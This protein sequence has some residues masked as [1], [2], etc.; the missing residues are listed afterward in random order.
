MVHPEAETRGLAIAGRTI[1][2]LASH[3]LTATGS[4]S[5]EGRG[6]RR[7]DDAATKRPR[8]FL[9]SMTDMWA[10]TMVL[11]DDCSVVPKTDVEANADENGTVRAGW[12]SQDETSQ[13]MSVRT[14]AK[15]LTPEATARLLIVIDSRTCSSTACALLDRLFSIN[16][17]VIIRP[18]RRQLRRLMRRPWIL[19]SRSAKWAHPDGLE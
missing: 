6:R 1:L 10:S 13:S 18:S 11:V 9:S 14:M 15:S 4:R 3:M 12:T 16:S 7:Q 2:G 8:R 5:A 17:S 19:N